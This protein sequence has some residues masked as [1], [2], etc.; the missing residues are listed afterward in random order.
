ML[1]DLNTIQD[2]VG[3]LVSWVSEMKTLMQNPYSNGLNIPKVLD[4]LA[5]YS[6]DLTKQV[7]ALQEKMKKELQ[8]EVE[9]EKAES[10]S[11][12]Q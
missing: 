8:P 5:G 2:K 6:A 9:N 3:L 7:Y 12:E 10:A 11:V 1:E 4:D